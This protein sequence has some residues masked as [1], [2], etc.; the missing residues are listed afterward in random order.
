MTGTADFLLSCQTYEGGFGG[1]PGNEA[2]GGYNF[3]ALAALLILGQV[4]KE[5]EG[6]GEGERYS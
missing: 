5:G 2:H 4:Y 3:C 6:E 1:E